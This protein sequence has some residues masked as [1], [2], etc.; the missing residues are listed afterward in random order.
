MPGQVGLAFLGSPPPRVASCGDFQ[1][2]M[3][4]EHVEVVVVMKD[5]CISANGDGSNETIDQLANGFPF[6]AT[7]A[8]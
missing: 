8:I 1:V 6:P 2:C 5:G 3:T 7:E 4:R